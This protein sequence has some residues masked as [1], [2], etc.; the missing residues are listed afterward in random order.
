MYTHIPTMHTDSK[1]TLFI[2]YVHLILILGESELET[3]G[4]EG[5]NGT[6]SR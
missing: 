3:C 5:Y 6:L 2:S 1:Y 4:L